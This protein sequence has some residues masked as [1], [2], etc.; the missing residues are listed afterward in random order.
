[1]AVNYL[2]SEESALQVVK[3]IQEIGRRAIAVRADCTDEAQVIGMVD[4]VVDEFGE[5]RVLVNNAGILSRHPVTEMDV[6]V[7][8][9]MMASHLRSTFL[10]SKYCLVKTMSSL[11][12]LAGERIAGKIINMSSGIVRRGGLGAANTAHYMA[13]KAGVIGFTSALAAEVAPLITVNAIAPGIHPTD[14]L[15]NPSE[16]VL[17]EL[18]RIFLLGLGTTEDVAAAA[19]FL[20]SSEGDHFTGETLTP[21][22]GAA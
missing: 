10:V 8:D 12:P 17:E 2:N 1:V 13:A 7:W 3:S 9:E 6:S 15:G 22:G 5:I 21:N 18:G 20:A 11:K 19:V 4:A 14:M 16:S